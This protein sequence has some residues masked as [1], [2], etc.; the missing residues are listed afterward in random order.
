MLTMKLLMDTSQTH[1]DG[2]CRGLAN[3]TPAVMMHACPALLCFVLL[4]VER[5]VPVDI[6]VTRD[7][8]SSSGRSRCFEELVV[9][10]RMYF[11]AASNYCTWFMDYGSNLFRRSHPSASS[12]NT[13][14]VKYV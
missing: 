12:L 1:T 3:E 5:K 8:R 13:V 6:L 4:L 2:D 14:L 11:V 9:K 7:Q 10:V